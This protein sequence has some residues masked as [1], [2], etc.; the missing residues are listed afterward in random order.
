M[1]HILRST[2][3][4]AIIDRWIPNYKKNGM[5]CNRW[6]CCSSAT[7]WAQLL[8]LPRSHFHPLQ[9]TIPIS[10]CLQWSFLPPSLALNHRPFSCL[11]F[12]AWNALLPKWSFHLPR[13]RVGTYT[14]VAHES[15]GH[16]LSYIISTS[17]C[18]ISLVNY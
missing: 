15:K 18:F 7:D 2:A 12:W 5:L 11:L 8:L 6:M 13:V 10:E 16:L 14:L 4:Q 17:L 3:E 9:F 1:I